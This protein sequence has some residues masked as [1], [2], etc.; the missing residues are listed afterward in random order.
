M[1]F[2]RFK[3]FQCLIFIVSILIGLDVWFIYNR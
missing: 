3:L 2:L 1:E